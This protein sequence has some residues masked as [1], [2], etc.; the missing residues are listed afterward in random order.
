VA[1]NKTNPAN[2]SDDKDLTRADSGRVPTSVPPG[3][4]GVS[5]EETVESGVEKAI[6]EYGPPVVTAVLV[7]IVAMAASA[8]YFSRREATVSNQWDSINVG[9]RSS[10]VSTLQGTADSARGTFVGAVAT[11]AAGMTELNAAL[12]KM[13]RDSAKAKEEIKSAMERFKQV[14]DYPYANDLLRQQAKYA[15]AFSHEAVGEF[16]A[17]LKLYQEV[18]ETEG[19]PLIRLAKDGV[20]RCQDDNIRSF[21]E[22]FAAWKPSESGPAPDLQN[23]QNLLNQDGQ[24]NLDA[25]KNLNIDAPPGLP[26][27]TPPAAT[28]GG[29]NP[30]PP[31]EAPPK[32]APS[33]GGGESQAPPAEAPPAEAPPAQTPPTENQGGGEATGG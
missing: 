12:E 27:Q 15:L 14:V 10:S 28:E 11:Q 13:V 8:F 2:T 7:V 4:P 6:K 1:T 17:A 32:E 30:V 29:E 19:S 20:L 26:G 31:T 5:L 16:D 9:L 18:S 3:A 22:K 33:T 25:L 23:L 24:L 21:Q